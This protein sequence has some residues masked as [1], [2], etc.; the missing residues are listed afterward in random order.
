MAN[1]KQP[2]TLVKVDA[3]TEDTFG[4]LPDPLPPEIQLDLTLT[5]LITEAT[6]ALGT[7][8][9]LG[10][11][12]ANPYLLIRPFLRREA[13][14]SSRIEGTRTELDQLLLFEASEATA[15][16]GSDVREVENYVRALEYGLAQ[17]S[18]RALST[19]LIKEMHAI[20]M[21]DVRGGD[22]HPGTFRNVQVYIGQR[23]AGMRAA[24]FIPP[25]PTEVPA[26]MRD[27]ERHIADP[28]DIPALI[29]IALIHY[30]FET[31]HPFEDGN[32]RLG[33]LLIPMLLG[34]WRLLDRPLLYLSDYFER[35]RDDYLDGLLHVSRN[36]D[37][38]GWIDF[39]LVA[40]R[41]QATDA[42]ERGKG[43]LNLREQYRQRY[44]V[45][46]SVNMLRII[47]E[48]FA[49]PAVTIG[50]IASRLGI[51]YT[52]AQ[53][54]IVALENDGV[55]QER[56]GRKRGRVYTAAEI[57]EILSGPSIE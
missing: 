5:N 24:R 50:G 52:S 44:Q 17:P 20:L 8:N 1:Q 7:L 33:R 42:L 25:P 48:L 16:A 47:D 10:Q 18:D 26:L 9:G 37:W 22:R 29:R 2:G 54:A 45:R 27:L 35:Y 30:Q 32:G 41:T 15:T 39:F 51:A 43:L 38:R 14:A 46:G 23:G 3:Q 11:T 49:Q 40:V 56:T 36:G 28:S 13:V 21:T 4:F 34:S 55:L 31:I 6:H 53:A 12:L 57:V 19:A